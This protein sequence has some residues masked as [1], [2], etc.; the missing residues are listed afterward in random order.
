MRRWIYL[1]LLLFC[2]KFSYSQQNDS[3][4]VTSP[5]K[6]LKLV[7]YNNDKPVAEGEVL[8]VNGTLIN[9]GLF[10]IYTPEGDVYQT[11]LYDKGKIVKVT[12]YN[13]ADKT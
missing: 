4:V 8:I 5:S 6:R 2:F 9:D 7:L 12:E 13:E 3:Y 1:L 10:I 11:V